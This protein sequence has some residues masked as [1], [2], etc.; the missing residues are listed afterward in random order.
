MSPR[1]T[2]L[3]ID[4]LEVAVARDPQYTVVRGLSLEV[5]EGEVLGIVGESGS[6]KS[7]TALSMVGLLPPGLRV[8]A[9]SISFKHEELTRASAGRL[10]AIRGRH[11]G[12][13]FQDP[14]AALDPVMKIGLQVSEPLLLHRLARRAQAEGRAVDGLGEVGIAAPR[15]S[16][17]RFPHEFSGGM[18]QRAMIATALI[19]APELIIADEPTTALDVTVQA[20][21]L[22][23]LQRLNR[24]RGVSL[25]LIS[26]DLDVVGE[27]CDRIAVMYAGRIVETGTTRDLLSEP[28]HPYTRALLESMP[29]KRIVRDTPLQAIPG[30][31]PTPNA[32]PGGCPFHP[33]C[34]YVVEQCRRAEPSLLPNRA[35]IRAGLSACWVAQR[36]Q[37]LERPR[38][39]LSTASVSAGVGP[40]AVR[41]ADDA[42][43]R[44]ENLRRFFRV[45]ARL[46]WQRSR[47]VHAVDGVS[48]M[49]GRGETLGIVGESGCGKSTLARCVLRLI[50]P[51]EGRIFFR[52][53]E[54][55]SL[56][57]NALWAMRRYM[58]PVFQD[59]YASL[60]PR[61]RVRQIVAEPLSA[62]GVGSAVARRRVD[63]TLELVGLGPSYGE[64]LPHQ[65]SGG[66]RQRVA[67]ARAIACRPDLLVTDEPLSSLDASIQAQI[68]NLLR[69]MQAQF[70]LSI[71]F[72]SHDLRV[73][74]YLSTT[75][76]VMYLG[77]V[78]EFGEAEAVCSN[79]RHPYTAALLSSI[80]EARSDHAP[81][82]RILLRGE[83]PSP[84]DPPSGCRFRTRCSFAGPDCELREPSLVDGPVPQV[85][86]HYPLR[87]VQGLTHGGPGRT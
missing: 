47:E 14:T 11:I 46:P 18:R 52:G 67:I 20:Q 66:Q 35:G 1:D 71:L 56:T 58:Q 77:K 62:Q 83:A 57:G 22:D 53:R 42:L 39:P 34:P 78:V 50:E 70:G 31:P 43:L 81:A 5:R 48:L 21:I 28:Q 60:N 74:R 82:D 73:V 10:A 9:G 19:A 27:F 65:L 13:V 33:R 40:T 37:G 44:V 55:T 84:M 80:P 41:P 51:D 45:G 4:G 59:P 76:A 7:V 69:D 12:F 25:I 6:G 8:S 26:H 24:D 3:R 29:S 30:E 32:L 61:W 85:A 17:H 38:P 2:L 79:P 64:R 23:L 68:V 63:E 87:E 49:L 72:V 54:L 16:S 15:E 86:C 36:A 75:I